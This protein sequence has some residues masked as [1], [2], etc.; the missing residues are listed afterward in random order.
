VN[1]DRIDFLNGN[2]RSAWE[3]CVGK[4]CPQIYSGK[5]WKCPPIT[6]FE[7][8]PTGIHVEPVWR[9]LAKSYKAIA[10]D[11]SDNDLATFLG[12]EEEDVCR[13]CPSQLERFELPN[14][15]KGRRRKLSRLS[16]AGANSGR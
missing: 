7:L 16:I 3:A 12:R 6:Y 13:L 8:L 4:H 5:L 15:L 1:G 10:P 11:C 14:P 9:D 2:P